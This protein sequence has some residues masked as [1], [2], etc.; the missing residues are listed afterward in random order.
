MLTAKA[1]V[2]G[3]H[4]CSAFPII[5]DRDAI[6]CSKQIPIGRHIH[7]VVVLGPSRRHPRAGTSLVLEVE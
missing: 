6:E 3:Q 7:P 2:I 4:G 5:V 1:T